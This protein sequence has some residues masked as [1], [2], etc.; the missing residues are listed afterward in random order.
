M[1]WHL[2]YSD[3]ARKQLRKFD[4]T[5]RTIIL[6]WIDK[7]INGCD[8]PR[9]HGGALVGNM[10][11][12]WRYR[13]GTYRVIADIQDNIVTIEIINVAHRKDVYKEL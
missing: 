9:L 7:N 5:Q 2:E 3:K 4:E 12:Y 10:K 6:R 13:V 1:I 8:N 11:G